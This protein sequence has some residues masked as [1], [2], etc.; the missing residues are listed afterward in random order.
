[1]PT[2]LVSGI[3]DQISSGHVRQRPLSQFPSEG[4]GRCKGAPGAYP[5]GV[6]ILL[7]LQVS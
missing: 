2:A 3:P 6:L 4:R 5:E 7:A 1:M